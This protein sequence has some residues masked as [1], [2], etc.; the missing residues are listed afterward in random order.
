MAEK[1]LDGADVRTAFKQVCGER[2]PKCMAPDPLR[3]SC[4][5]SG[6]SHRPLHR[7]LVKVKPGRRTKPLVPADPRGGK[8]EL[9]QPVGA[10]I[11]ILAIESP[12]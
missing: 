7:R 3:E 2:V 12:R 1:L 8:D 4:L 9:L 10:R 11:R 5:P 6:V